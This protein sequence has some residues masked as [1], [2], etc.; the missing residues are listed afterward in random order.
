LIAST[1]DAE[2][3]VFTNDISKLSLPNGLTVLT[4]RMEHVRSISMGI[5]LKT[6]AGDDAPSH[7]GLSH[8]VEHA[9]FDGTTSRSAEQISFDSEAEG[10]FVNAFTG[11][12][13]TAFYSTAIDTRAKQSRALL[14]DLILNPTFAS[15]AIDRARGVILEE[16]M[17]SQ[18]EPTYDVQNA[19]YASLWNNHPFSL[20][21][22]GRPETLASF[23]S[24]TLRSFADTHF[25]GKNMVLAAA[26]NLRHEE[27]AGI[28]A[29]HLGTA[30]PGSEIPRG[31]TPK[32][33]PGVRLI[34][35]PT[36]QV[37]I[38]IGWPAVPAS[39]PQYF[40]CRMLGGLLGAGPGSRLFRALRTQRGLVYDAFAEYRPFSQVGQFVVEAST[41]TENVKEVVNIILQECNRVKSTRFSDEEMRRIKA[42]IV[43]NQILSHETS[44]ARVDTLASQYLTLGRS[45][46]PE[47]IREEIEAV[48]AE[49]IIGA[50]NAF[51]RPEHLVAAF[52]GDLESASFSPE[53]LNF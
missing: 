14:S 43:N 33:L 16:I 7:S 38:M 46:S 26:G 20:P 37:Q 6:G 45:V 40:T 18:A 36:R 35:K 13:T 49:Q 10:G 11:L 47:Q 27:I 2:A 39:N 9:V 24:E 8:F 15:E 17:A 53:K 5:W 30:L 19:F 34:Q 32:A 51:M 1:L 22:A 31:A 41:S 21:V 52:A 50:A 42:Q 48:T 44:S 23:T 29:A 4:E 12:E 28:A 25:V 3:D